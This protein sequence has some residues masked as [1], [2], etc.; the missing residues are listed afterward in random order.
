M[1]KTYADI[2]EEKLEQKIQA[3]AGEGN[4]TAVLQ[5]LDD[6]DAN[7][8]RRELEHRAQLDITIADRD[9]GDGEG[10]RAAVLLRLSRREDFEEHIF[11]RRPEDLYQLAGD[12]SVSTALR[13]LTPIQSRVLFENVVYG[14]P[15]K[16]IAAELG[17]SRRNITK[18]RQTALAKL[19]YLAAVPEV[20]G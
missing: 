18:H 14:V 12:R 17:C 15:A 10:C 11:S 2:R 1:R 5:A 19:R 6:F 8:E 9:L 16:E 20:K 13:R 7:N 4:W 3:L